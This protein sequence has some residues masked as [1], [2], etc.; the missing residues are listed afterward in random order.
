M[1]MRDGKHTDETMHK[2]LTYY[3]VNGQV[4]HGEY[5]GKK[6]LPFVFSFTDTPPKEIKL[7]DLELA[8]NLELPDMKNV[9]WVEVELLTAVLQPKDIDTKNWINKPTP[10][11]VIKEKK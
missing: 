5:K 3:V 6:L 4:T 9:Y 7:S 2:G 8:R 11:P 1:F 10:M